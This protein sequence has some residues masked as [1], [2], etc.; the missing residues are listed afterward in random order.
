MTDIES[1]TM[2]RPDGVK[3]KKLS[4]TRMIMPLTMPTRTES[5]IFHKHEVKCEKAL[6]MADRLTEEWGMK[7]TLFNMIVHSFL[8]VMVAYPR[9]NRFVSGGRIYQRNGIHFSY[10][11]KRQFTSKASV[12]VVK[13]EFKPE[14]TLKDTVINM[15]RDIKHSRENRE[16]RSDKEAKKWLFAPPIIFHYGHRIYKFVDN[17]LGLIPKKWIY[18]DPFYATAF[19]TNVGVFGVNGM[20][21]HLYEHG[22]IPYFFLIGAIK[23][24]P[25]VEDGKVVVRKVVPVHS[26]VDDRV[27]DGF[28]L[29]RCVQYFVDNIENPEELL[30]PTEF[31][32]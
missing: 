29:S 13:R 6:E 17:Y 15:S 22:N 23:E 26:S 32:D 1:I 24:I 10:S 21:H 18:N 25:V 4:S 5:V 28:Y 30:K 3:V 14:F 2:G 12:T 27:E 7:V 19:I 11:V 20:Y 16:N 8:K 9:T 31:I